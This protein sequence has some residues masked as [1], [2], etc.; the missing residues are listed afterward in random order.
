MLDK[1]LVKNERINLKPSV[2]CN[3]LFSI[4]KN[5]TDVQGYWLDNNGKLYIDNIKIEKYLA[6]DTVCLNGR[7][8]SLFNEGEKCVFY[9]DIYNFGILRYPDGKWDILKTRI[10]MIEHSKPSVEYIKELLKNNNGL[11]VY[12]ID[13]GKYLIEIYS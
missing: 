11:T 3:S 9:K 4:S 10:E 12:A 6:I 8:K 5:E 7:I 1:L 2:L 13:N